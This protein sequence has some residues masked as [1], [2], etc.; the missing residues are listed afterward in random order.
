MTEAALYSL[1]FF[2][3]VFIRNT[4]EKAEVWMFK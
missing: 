3:L 2:Q 4:A 1:A